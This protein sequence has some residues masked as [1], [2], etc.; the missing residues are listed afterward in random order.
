M[1]SLRGY[2]PLW[3]SPTGGDQTEGGAT[4]C[5]ARGKPVTKMLLHLQEEEQR[6]RIPQKEELSTPSKGELPRER[7]GEKD[8]KSKNVNNF[9]TRRGGPLEVQLI[10]GEGGSEGKRAQ[11]KS[12]VNFSREEKGPFL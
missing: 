1:E 8:G 7:E 10:R 12:D 11:K 6:R 4:W 2:S 9:R 5:C 3:V